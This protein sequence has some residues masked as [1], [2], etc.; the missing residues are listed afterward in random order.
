M[1]FSAALAERV[2]QHF[3]SNKTIKEKKMFGGMAFLLNG[4]LCVGIWQNSL[5]ARLGPD[6]GAAALAESF[7]S[8]FNVNGRPMRGWVLI[9]A[10][11]VDGDEDLHLWIERS[12]AFVETLPKK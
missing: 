9:A 11:G 10:E 3:A 2:R 7:V 6:N 8:Q 1:V 4:N 5:L 12:L